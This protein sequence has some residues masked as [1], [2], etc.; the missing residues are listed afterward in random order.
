MAELDTLVAHFAA[1]VRACVEHLGPDGFEARFKHPNT[2]SSAVELANA[3]ITEFNERSAGNVIQDGGEVSEN[4]TLPARMTAPPSSTLLRYF[5]KGG[6][7]SVRAAK[8]ST[9]GDEDEPKST[10]ED[11]EMST[12]SGPGP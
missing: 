5:A 12:A 11:I 8:A 10:G 4:E 1:H 6:P 7:A 2:S 9:V 3:F